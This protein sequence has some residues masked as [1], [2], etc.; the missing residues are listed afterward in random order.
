M[1]GAAALPPGPPAC[2][3]KWRVLFP[4]YHR[5]SKLARLWY[6]KMK[7]CFDFSYQGPAGEGESAKQSSEKG[8]GQQKGLSLHVF[9]K[10][11][12]SRVVNRKRFQQSS[13]NTPRSFKTTPR[14]KPASSAETDFSK[15]ISSTGKISNEI[16]L[17]II[18]KST[19]N[20]HFSLWY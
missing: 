3:P 6:K 16:Y 11:V 15:I 19:F 9:L 10:S 17:I 14:N 4:G 13:I 2:T 12:Q 7:D 1:W 20:D 8:W 5:C 18:P